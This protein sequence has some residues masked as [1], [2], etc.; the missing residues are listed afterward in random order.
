MTDA[1]PQPGT[2]ARAGRPRRAATRGRPAPAAGRRWLGLLYLAP[3]S[4]STPRRAVP[5]GQGVWLSF[6]HWNGVTAATWAGLSNYTG[7]LHD[8]TLRV[9]GLE[10]TLF[11]IALLLA[12]ADRPGAGSAPR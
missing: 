1:D 5:A 2:G 9:S 10:H 12:A 3:R 11:F 4:S 8:P 7:F 6:F